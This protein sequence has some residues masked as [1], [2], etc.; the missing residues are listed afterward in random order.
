MLLIGM[1]RAAWSVAVPVSVVAY[2][3]GVWA[4]PVLVWVFWKWVKWYLLGFVTKAS[5]ALRWGLWILS[6]FTKG[7]GAAAA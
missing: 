6:W 5:R 4:S 2:R 7:G 1:A 3:I